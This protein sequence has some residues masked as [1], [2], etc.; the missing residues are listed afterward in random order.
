MSTT[1][2]AVG[3]ATGRDGR[4]YTSDGMLDVK[5][6]L[7]PQLGGDGAGT[8]PEQLFAVG[9]A[10]CFASVIGVIADQRRLDVSEVSVTAEI[11]LAPDGEGGFALA[12]TLRVEFPDGFA[13]DQA[14]RRELVA[15][16]HRLCPYS[17][18][19][20]GNMPV[21]LVVE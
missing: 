18:A 20:R 11:G 2:T 15:D 12:G 14:A 1:Y 10:A 7:P 19:T 17:R 21:E 9:Y 4:G 16:A 8:N 3:T 13:L 5:L 6:A